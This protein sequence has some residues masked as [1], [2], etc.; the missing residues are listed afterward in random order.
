M[1]RGRRPRGR[2]EGFTL[3]ELMVV[4]L[5]I[6]ILIAIAIPTFLGAR[7]RAQ[8]RAAQSSLRNALTAAKAIYADQ[9]DYT[10]ADVATL[11]AEEK[12][13]TFQAAASTGANEIS[14]GAGVSTTQV[15]YAA[16]QSASGT[17]F[18]VKDDAGAGG[19]TGYG[20]DTPASCAATA[21]PTGG[22]V[23]KW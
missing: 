11:T 20:S 23:S 2:D 19:G 16:A 17:C 9:Q 3:I 4:V 8:D 10:K 15:F 22:Y 7:Q 1:A 13:L 5:I 14:L 18:Y 6:A 21:T 12:N